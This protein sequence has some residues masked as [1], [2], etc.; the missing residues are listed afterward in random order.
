[1]LANL[2]PQLP[3]Y[4]ML[5]L[6]TVILR[7]IRA[8]RSRPK[9]DG[10]LDE[11]KLYRVRYLYFGFELVNVSAGVFI[12]LTENATK[13]VGTVMIMYVI[14]VILSF[15]FEDEGVGRK[16]KTAGHIWVS[17]TVLVVT[18]YAFLGV[19]GLASTEPKTIIQS[20]QKWRVAL[21]YMDTSLNRNFGIKAAPLQSVFIEEVSAPS[22]L[23][24]LRAVKANFFSEKGPYPFVAK[25]EKTPLSM[26]VLESDAVV[27]SLVP[28]QDD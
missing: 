25:V 2:N 15:F 9:D 11:I 14:L 19:K 5:Y 7:F 27:E 24:A 20:A 23:D 8:Y 10:N 1:M 12:L 18:L 13:Y 28:K 21:P 16:L 22:R 4:L 3:Y 6:L 26:V 17:L